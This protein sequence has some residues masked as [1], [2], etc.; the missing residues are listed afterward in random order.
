MSSTVYGASLRALT[1]LVL[2]GWGCGV[3]AQAP[4]PS[5]I[6]G[7]TIGPIESAQHPERGY[8]T[9]AS[10]ATLDALVHLGVNTIS[11]TPFARIW[12]L[13][14][15]EIQLDFEAPYEE[16]R[17]AIGRLVAQAHARGL[18]VVLIPHLWVETGGWR[19]EIAP[20]TAAAF[21]AYRAAYRRFILAWARDAARF[22]VD[23]LSIGVECVSWS[24]RFG[25]FWTELIADVRE[26]YSGPLTYSANWDEVENVLFWDQ[27]DWIG[28]NAFYPLSAH[29]GAS[30]DT[31]LQGAARA[32]AGLAQIAA[33][34]GKPAVL[35]EI[36]YT[37]R[38]DA[39]VQPW[40]WPDHML[41]VI[42][43]EWEQAR[44]LSALMTAAA[45]E[46]SVIGF[47]VW[48]YYADLD[49]VSQEAPWGF[50]T[51]GKLADHVLRS[52][53]ARPW[54]GEGDAQPWRRPALSP[55]RFLYTPH[56]WLRAPLAAER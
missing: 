17:Q 34:H 46:P 1:C 48:R 52:V 9:A 42:V 47:F 26:V 24:G 15:S 35:M 44:A 49:D 31:Y 10:A 40:L 2:L 54:A 56:P 37:T 41:D 12:S 51:Y 29:A 8:G 13:E 16:N 20:P 45:L 7:M 14:S 53:F 27:L 21:R 11:V 3:C 36:G 6:R 30:Y 38:P 28:V 55:K 18:R 5:G 25:A 33:L 22:D 23:A 39:A 32:I 4:P 43:D 50:S 19:G